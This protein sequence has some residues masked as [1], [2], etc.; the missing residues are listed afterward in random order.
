M[1][2]FR[3]PETLP[4][5]TF[6]LLSAALDAVGAVAPG[7]FEPGRQR[8][9]ATFI[10]PGEHPVLEEFWTR[11]ECLERSGYEVWG[12]LIGAAWPR[13]TALLQA[14]L[15]AIFGCGAFEGHVRRMPPG[16][17]SPSNSLVSVRG[18]F[19]WIGPSLVQGQRFKGPEDPPEGVSAL[20]ESIELAFCGFSNFYRNAVEFEPALASN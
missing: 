8:R 14:R 15:D 11:L 20:F 12:L 6:P 9:I 13:Q 16:L 5:L 4:G 3:P 19:A 18:Q 10:L 1:L 17:R 7:Q 2:H